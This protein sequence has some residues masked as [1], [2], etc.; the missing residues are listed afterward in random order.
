VYVPFTTVV[1]RQVPASTWLSPTPPGTVP[2][3]SEQ[4]GPV[5]V[6]ALMVTGVVLVSVPA[7]CL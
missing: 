6:A 3:L 2:P 4:L 5:R 1:V 7:S